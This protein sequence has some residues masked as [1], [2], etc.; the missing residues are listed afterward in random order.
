MFNWELHRFGIARILVGLYLLVLINGV[1]F[2]HAHRL[3]D[4]TIICHAHP[5][6]GTPGT[7]Y[8]NHTHTNDQFIWLDAFANALYGVDG[9]VNWTPLVLII[10]LVA[11]TRTVR[12]VRSFSSVHV[13]FRHRGPPVSCV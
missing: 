10:W 3:A 5:F 2:R 1:L 9:P 8:P 12:T 4:G 11:T 6:K 13:A 7:Q